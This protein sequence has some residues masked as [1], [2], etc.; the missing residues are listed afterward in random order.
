MLQAFTVSVCFAGYWV[1][2][3]MYAATMLVM[4]HALLT[5][6]RYGRYFF[7]GKCPV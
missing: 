6:G 2:S 4:L 3:S 7:C 1:L 5:V